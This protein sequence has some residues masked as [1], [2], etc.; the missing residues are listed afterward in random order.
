MKDVE[1]KVISLESNTYGKGL[2]KSSTVWS[3][4]LRRAVGKVYVDIIF[5]EKSL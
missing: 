3:K 1:M 5:T 2:Q 4:I